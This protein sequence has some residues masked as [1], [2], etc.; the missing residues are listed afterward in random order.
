MKMHEHR[1]TPAP[2]MAN[3]ALASRKR[4]FKML[5]C[6]AF[7]QYRLVVSRPHGD[8]KFGLYIP[9]KDTICI[10]PTLSL[11]DLQ[12]LDMICIL[13]FLYFSSRLINGCV[14]RGYAEVRYNYFFE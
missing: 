4:K 6:E 11:G 9:L 2:V 13:P 10:L 12:L 8:Q 5:D 3:V 1:N 7:L 14:Y